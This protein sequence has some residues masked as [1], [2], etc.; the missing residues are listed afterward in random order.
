MLKI[1]MFLED[2]IS[3]QPNRSR[4]VTIESADLINLH[5]KERLLLERESDSFK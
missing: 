4:L 3:T 1:A 2:V 5:G